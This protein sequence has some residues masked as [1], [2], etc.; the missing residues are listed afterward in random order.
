VS[1]F[2]ITLGRRQSRKSSAGLGL[3]GI[4]IRR[5]RGH[6]SHYKGIGLLFSTSDGLRPE[7]QRAQILGGPSK[8]LANELR[9]SERFCREQALLCALKES[10]EAFEEMAARYRAAAEAEE[11]KDTPKD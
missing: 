1:A 4:T 2:R 9:E 10:R 5:A 11:L 6:F 3:A 8:T 7:H